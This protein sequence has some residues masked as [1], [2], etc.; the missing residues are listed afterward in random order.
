VNL[1]NNS[2]QK[3]GNQLNENLSQGS[4]DNQ[5]DDD[6]TGLQLAQIKHQNSQYQFRN[7]YQEPVQEYKRFDNNFAL[8]QSQ[9]ISDSRPLNDVQ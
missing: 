1:T 5:S 7:Q 4:P 3:K 8:P 6:E 9:M 2:S